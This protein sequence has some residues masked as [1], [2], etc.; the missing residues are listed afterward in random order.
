MKSITLQNRLSQMTITD[1]E[2]LTVVNAI[3]KGETYCGYIGYSVAK[4]SSIQAWSVNPLYGKFDEI[5]SALSELGLK[6]KSVIN[7]KGFDIKIKNKI[8]YCYSL[9][10]INILILKQIKH[11]FRA[12]FL[13]L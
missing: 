4:T 8:Q 12:V 1:S 9:R 13:L 6:L 7:S 3:I 5:V 10:K 2:V 11:C